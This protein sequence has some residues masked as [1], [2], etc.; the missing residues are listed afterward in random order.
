MVLLY[1]TLFPMAEHIQTSD[2]RDQMVQP[3]INAIYL[4]TNLTLGLLIKIFSRSLI[5]LYHR[6]F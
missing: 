6:T 4:N 3:L 5:A 1:R 2:R